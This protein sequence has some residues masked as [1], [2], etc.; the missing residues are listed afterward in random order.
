MSANSERS[1]EGI[2]RDVQGRPLFVVIDGVDGCGKSTQARKLVEHLIQHQSPSTALDSAFA[3]V[4][5]REPGSTDLGERVRALLLDRALHL[6]AEVETLLFAAARRQMLDQLVAPAL[7]EGRDVV[8]ERFHPST[9]AYQAVAGDLDPEAVLELLHSWAN[10]PAPD[11]IILLDI[12]IEDAARRRGAATDRIE[13]KGTEF[14]LRVAEGYRIYAK[15][16]PRVVV[17]DGARDSEQVAADIATVV[18]S[19]RQEGSPCS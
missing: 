18:E 13:D 15:Q 16:N 12:P 19:A 4:H 6:E 8:C 11:L 7:R 9:F 2:G 1:N 5:L 14:Q 3:P 17:I 10:Q